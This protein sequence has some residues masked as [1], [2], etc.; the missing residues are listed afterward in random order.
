MATLEI[1]EQN[2]TDTIE[3]HPIVILDFWATWCMPCLGF[4]QVYDAA[5]TQHEDIV[6]GKI[7]TDA[8]RGLAGAFNIRSIP[9]LVVLR[10]QVVVYRESGAL[11]AASLELLIGRVRELDMDAVRVELAQQKKA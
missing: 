3:K 7:D 10:D 6:F 8:E 4:S 1:T 5:A 9:T 2:F 11:P